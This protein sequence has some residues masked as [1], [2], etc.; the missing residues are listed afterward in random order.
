MTS[1]DQY[2]VSIKT[3]TNDNCNN[4][5]EEED[6]TEE[7]EDEKEDIK[8]DLKDSSKPPFSYVAMIGE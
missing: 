5:D 8:D 2:S 1:S 7:D 3:E 4:L 6:T